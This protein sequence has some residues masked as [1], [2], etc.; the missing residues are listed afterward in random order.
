MHFYN[1]KKVVWNYRFMVSAR[2]ISLNFRGE[3]EI[4]VQ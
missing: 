3:Y 1:R 2:D 4:K